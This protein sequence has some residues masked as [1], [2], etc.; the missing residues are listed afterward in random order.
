MIIKFYLNHIENYN[1]QVSSRLDVTI[2]FYLNRENY[3]NKSG[4]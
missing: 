1:Y 2:K 4:T 3:N